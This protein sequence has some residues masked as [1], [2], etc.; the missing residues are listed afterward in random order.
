MFARITDAI[1]SADSSCFVGV[2]LNGDEEAVSS[3]EFAVFFKLARERG[4][5]V[6]VH[7]G[8]CGPASNVEYAAKE[9]GASRIGHGIAARDDP[10]ILRLLAER[11]CALEICPTSNEILQLTTETRELPLETL[12][13]HGVPF[14]IC[15][16][17]PARCSTTL[18]EELFK[19]AKAFGLSPADIEGLV[20]RSLVH[21]FASDEAK[22]ELQ[23]TIRT[24]SK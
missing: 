2:D 16:D 11:G 13:E 8:E 23:E 21:A 6:T 19:V 9:L 20:H 24:Q 22:R 4:L 12:R 5:N 1:A 15:T 18:S 17:N 3:T 10:Q 7:A 14:V